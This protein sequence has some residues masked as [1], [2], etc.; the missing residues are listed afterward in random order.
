MA[1][2][3][4]TSHHVNYLIWRYLQESG[5]GDAAVSL[6]RAWFPDPQSLPFARHIKTHALVSLVQKGLQYHEL[7]SS[8]D[9][10]F[11]ASALKR[12]DDDG[13]D[14]PAEPARDRTTN[15]HSLDSRSRKETNGDES[16]EVDDESKGSVDGDG[17]I[18]P[19]KAADLAPD[20]ALLHAQ[21][22]VL[23]TR[24][25]PRDSTLLVAAGDTFCS[26]WKLSLSS[27]PEQNRFLDLKGTNAYVSG[28]A[29]DALGSKLAVATIR[30]T[31][32]GAITMYNPEGNVVDLL[33]D[34]PRLI[35]GLHWSKDSPQLVVVASD[36]RSSELAL[37]DDSRR[38]DVYPPP[39]AID[40]HVYELAWCGR[41][42]VFACGDGAVYQCEV[43]DNIRLTKT[44]NSRDTDTA[45]TFVR[46]VHTSSYSVA[47]AA[48]STNCSIWIPTHDI[49]IENP[50]QD[51]ITAIDIRP[52]EH[53]SQQNSTITIASF[54][55]DNFVHVWE[56]DLDSKQ[57]KRIHRLR[58]GS[59]TPA[60]AGSFSPDG[61]ALCAVSEQKLLIWNAERG[62]EPMAIWMA[63]GPEQVKEDP[64]H[65]TNG[66]NGHAAT[67][68]NRD[69]SWDH[70]GKKLA[71]GFGDQVIRTS[72]RQ[73]M[74][75]LT[76]LDGH[77]QSSAVTRVAGS[78]I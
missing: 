19:A 77:H 34:L 32:K 15:G 30:D 28:V 27:P 51:A 56:V 20:T 72:P 64:D 52:A 31:E 1:Q 67:A 21:D 8:L 9:K 78:P 14:H 62:G 55:T 40:S 47:V 57:H 37:W 59:S 24:W 10:P 29:W 3:D 11:E 48:S 50:H 16:M 25:R 49:L 53:H 54:S 44:Y 18:S 46:S 45:W 2:P 22:H 41:N 17:D 12:R 60:L 36:E 39:Q 58:L 13:T 74:P 33:P 26:L 68:P 66:Q 70:D 6:Q 76:L 71:Y 5:H 7:E 61:Y 65:P 63:P 69:L 43:D 38:P 23:T 35:N 75:K 4:L 42:L 73:I